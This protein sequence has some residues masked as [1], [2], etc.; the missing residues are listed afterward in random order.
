MI[1][2]KKSHAVV[3][4]S[5]A[6]DSR[7]VTGRYTVAIAI[8]PKA[9]TTATMGV[10]SRKTDLQDS[11]RQVQCHK[12]ELLY[13]QARAGQLDAR[14]QSRFQTQVQ[15]LRKV[16]RCWEMRPFLFGLEQGLRASATSQNEPLKL[17]GGRQA[18]RI[19]LFRPLVVVQTAFIF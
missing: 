10:T 9:R 2:P 7:L 17:G 18:A 15:Y 6:L 19:D 12:G 5:V 11:S 16:P 1:P 3:Q 8:G 4:S 13:Q 14:R